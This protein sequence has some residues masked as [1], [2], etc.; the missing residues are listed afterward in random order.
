MLLDISDRREAE[1]RVHFQAHLLEQV[2]AAV[3]ATDMQG[4]VTHW[5]EHA[6]RLYGWSCEEAMGRHIAELTVEPDK[7]GVAEEIMQTLRE[8]ETWEGEF[9][10][11]RK[12]G[13]T[14]RR[15]RTP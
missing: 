9:V 3:I 11:R 2:Q 13:S 4:R 5:N 10:V 12:D 15:S 1:E 6:E 14:F 8:G 7:A